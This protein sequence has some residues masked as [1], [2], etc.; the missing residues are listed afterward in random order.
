MQESLNIACH[1]MKRASDGNLYDINLYING[2]SYHYG[3]KHSHD[4][5]EFAFLQNGSLLNKTQFGT[6]KLNK[7]DIMIM[8]P[9][10]QHSLI[11]NENSDYLLYNIE[12]NRNFLK[13][14]V[15][16]I[17]GAN[18][19]DIL[20][21]PIYYLPCS[22][23]EVVQ[24]NDLI[25]LATKEDSDYKNKQFTLKLLVML[26]FTKVYVYT[27]NYKQNQNISSITLNKILYELKDPDNF[28]YNTNF[29]FKKHNYSQEHVIRFFK[30]AGLESPNKIF[31]QNKMSYARNLLCN[32]H[33]KIT[34]IAE[35]CGIF[36]QN[37]FCSTFKKHYGLSPSDYRR[38]F[39]NNQ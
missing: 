12:I 38:K 24:I 27:S 10:C 4:H 7:N 20:T 6:R 31:M 13:N 35:L 16:N 28:K 14:I 11:V 8:R 25:S 37:Y 3:H 33:M 34:D 22:T 32:S 23:Q 18:V 9:E 5:F 36:T 30:K 15:N 29:L 2:K 17:E 19:D 39:S 21:D 1:T 26:I